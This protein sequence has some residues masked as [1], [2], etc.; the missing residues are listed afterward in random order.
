MD[1]IDKAAKEKRLMQATKNDYM[2]SSGKFGVIVKYLGYPIVRQGSQEA[3]FS[4]D[5]LLNLTQD[6]ALPVADDSY[7]FQEGWIFDGLSRGMHIEIKYIDPE[8]RLV[9]HYKGFRVY[10]EIA[11]DLDAFVP[12]EWEPL[13]ERLYKVAAERR[14]YVKREMGQVRK[15]EVLAEQQGFL[16]RLRSRWGL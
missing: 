9:V 2:G 11:G 3:Y 12:G 15:A 14:K 5:D 10:E 8:K 7:S 6:E 1:K 4:I 13:I 16:Q